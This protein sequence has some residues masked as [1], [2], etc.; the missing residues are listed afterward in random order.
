MCGPFVWRTGR[1]GVQKRVARRATPRHRTPG[2]LCRIGTIRCGGWL[3][4]A[5]R[6][7]GPATNASRGA[8]R[9]S[10][11]PDLGRSTIRCCAPRTRSSTTAASGSST[12]STTPEALER[13]AAL[14]EPAGVLQL[15]VGPPRATA[16]RSRS[17]SASPLLMLPGRAARTRRSRVLNLDSS[18]LEGARA[19]VAGAA[20]ASSS[21]SR[22]APRTHYAVGNGPAGV[23]M[24]R[25]PLPPDA[26]ASRS[27][28]STCWSGTARRSTA[29]R[30]RPRC[31]TR[32]TARGATFRRSFCKLPRPHARH[33]TADAEVA[34]AACSPSTTTPSTAAT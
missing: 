1:A 15:F 31:S 22:S 13:A 29:A 7:V 32:S 12:R 16:R 2:R 4:H 11:G 10:A 27:C 23:H 28:P 6:R 24:M 8:S 20:R 25:R 34:C 19:V 9:T 17:G 3:L 5:R 33:A 18:G 21:P 14:G 26:P 30:R